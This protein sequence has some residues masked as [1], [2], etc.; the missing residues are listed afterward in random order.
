VVDR[1]DGELRFEPDTITVF[2]LERGDPRARFQRSIEVGGVD[3]LIDFGFVRA[4]E[5]SL[6][7]REKLWARMRDNEDLRRRAGFLAEDAPLRYDEYVAEPS[8]YYAS[9]QINK[10]ILAMKIARVYDGAIR[11]LAPADFIV[12]A[13]A[14]VEL[15]GLNRIT[16]NRVIIAGTL[17]VYGHLVIE[18][19]ELRGSP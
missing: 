8:V 15:H 18:A 9:K 13:G 17:N 12:S 16:A 4:W 1:I 10:N 14:T 5:F 6:R 2:P 7:E 3:D 19:D 11:E